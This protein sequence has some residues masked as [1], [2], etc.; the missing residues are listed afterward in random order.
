MWCDCRHSGHDPH[1]LSSY[2]LSVGAHSNCTS[3]PLSHGEMV[4]LDEG[5]FPALELNNRRL[6]VKNSFCRKNG[7]Y[8]R[9]VYMHETWFPSI[10]YIYS[11]ITS[12][13]ACNSSNWIYI[14]I[15]LMWCLFLD[16]FLS[17]CCS[18]YYLHNGFNSQMAT[19]KEPE[20]NVFCPHTELWPS[21]WFKFYF[22]HPLNGLSWHGF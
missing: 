12:H 10:V 22:R 21:R 2:L 8:T 17:V 1:R 16:M 7:I 19:N 9:L 14:E 13:R 20:R 5:R 15:V 6:S 11:D 18:G 4:R 3:L